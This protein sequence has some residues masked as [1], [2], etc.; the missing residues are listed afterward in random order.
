[1]KHFTIV[2]LCFSE[3][4]TAQTV[5]NGPIINFDKARVADC[6]MDTNQ[7]QWK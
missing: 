7:H 6:K 4:G 2:A 3:L 1:M 5:W